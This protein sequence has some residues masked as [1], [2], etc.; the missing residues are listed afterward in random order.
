LSD[1]GESATLYVYVCSK[2]EPRPQFRKCCS[3]NRS[4][5]IDGTKLNCNDSKDFTEHFTTLQRK[6]D[7]E[8]DE[9]TFTSMTYLDDQLP[10]VAANCLP[11]NPETDSM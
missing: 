10:T 9:P 8:E 2:K 6:L 5:K 11:S 7:I 1:N 4:F 3:W